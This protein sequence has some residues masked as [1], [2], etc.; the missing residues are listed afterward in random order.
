MN[1]FQE[2][3]QLVN[4]GATVLSPATTARNQFTALRHRRA[5]MRPT[6]RVFRP[7][8]GDDGTEDLQSPMLGT[9]LDPEL[10]PLL[11]EMYE[12]GVLSREP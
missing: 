2:A 3:T 12:R 5:G 4:T 6:L 9:T 7:R 1:L 11:N 8:R 10:R